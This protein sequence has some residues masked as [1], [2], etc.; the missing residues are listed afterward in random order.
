MRARPSLGAIV[1]GTMS[2][3]VRGNLATDIVRAER[4]R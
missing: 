4:K 2:R 1:R 3:T